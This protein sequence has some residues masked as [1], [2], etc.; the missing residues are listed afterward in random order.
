MLSSGLGKYLAPTALGAGYA[1]VKMLALQAVDSELAV[2]QD[3]TFQ[4]LAGV[5]I[6][7]AVRPVA[8]ML[9]WTPRAATGVLAWLL[10][11]A[12]PLGAVLDRL[13]WRLPLD[14]AYWIRMLPDA[15]ALIGVAVFAPLLVPSEVRQIHFRLLRGRMRYDCDRIG[16][17][18]LIGCG[19]GYPVLFVAVYALITG[20]G[21][22]TATLTAGREFL[23]HPELE[24]VAV[25]LALRGLVLTLALWP[26]LSVF[27]RGSVELTV[28]LGSLVFVVAEF[29]PAFANFDQLDPF[30][31]MDQVLEGLLRMFL[32]TLLVVLC[33]G[34]RPETP[35]Q[36]GVFSR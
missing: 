33:F 13:V 10:L 28:V 4:F 36:S 6:G 21:D 22:W 23:G 2:V 3:F 1:I 26:V 8:K 25:L 27:L 7:F 15:A 20:D 34:R 14:E 24:T 32:F 31:L 19:L 17:L 11:L 5:L 9:Y 18:K 30:L 29:G 35:L 16:L 12:G